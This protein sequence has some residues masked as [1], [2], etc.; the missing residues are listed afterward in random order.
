MSCDTVGESFPSKYQQIKWIVS[1]QLI[2]S[3]PQKD[4]VELKFLQACVHLAGQ[5][6]MKD[7]YS[8]SLK[9]KD[10][11]RGL[12]FLLRSPAQLYRRRPKTSNKHVISLDDG[13]SSPAAQR[14]D[15]PAPAEPC[16][17]VTSANLRPPTAF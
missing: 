8:N 9:M 14:C 16:P 13:W 4:V 15:P 5:N 17:P 3:I 7:A 12:D 2:S 1:L 6:T 11:F 10:K